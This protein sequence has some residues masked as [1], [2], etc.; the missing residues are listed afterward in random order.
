MNTS[1]CPTRYSVIINGASLKSSKKITRKDEMNFRM[2]LIIV[3]LLQKDRTIKYLCNKFRITTSSLKSYFKKIKEIC[4]ET[5]DETNEQVHTHKR[6][7][8]VS[9]VDDL[10]S[11]KTLAWDKTGNKDRVQILHDND[12][13]VHVIEQTVYG[14]SKNDWFNKWHT[15]SFEK[16]NT[17]DSGKKYYGKLRPEIFTRKK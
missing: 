7:Y 16:M 11:L 12:F 13:Y 2:N 4:F 14:K 1:S 10:V 5:N 17:W 6:A 9:V 3:E 8:N 15:S